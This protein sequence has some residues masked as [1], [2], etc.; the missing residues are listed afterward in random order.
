MVVEPGRRARSL[1]GISCTDKPQ[2]IEPVVPCGPCHVVDTV[3]SKSAS[4]PLPRGSVR[5]SYFNPCVSTS[6][7]RVGVQ[8]MF[9]VYNPLWEQV[10]FVNR[11][12]YDRSFKLTFPI[13]RRCHLEFQTMS[14]ISLCTCQSMLRSLQLAPFPQSTSSSL[15]PSLIK[16]I[17]IILVTVSLFYAQECFACMYV[18]TPCAL[19]AHQGQKRGYWIS[20]DWLTNSCKLPLGIESRSSVRLQSALNC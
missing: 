17:K 15:L 9:V 18:C 4:L 14:Q 2:V 10:T 1:T 20:W 6:C 12:L 3:Q 13:A 16:K 8:H 7:Q 19:G 11:E 5:K